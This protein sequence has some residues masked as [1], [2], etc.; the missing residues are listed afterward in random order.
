MIL[1][2]THKTLY[3]Y[4]MPS[5]ESHNEV[6]LMPL[7]DWTQSCIE[8]HLRVNPHCR[9]FSYEETGGTVHYFGVRSAHPIL[10]IIAEAVVETKLENPFDGLNLIEPDWQFYQLH[11][12]LQDNAEFLSE[13]PYVV[14]NQ[15]V[16]DIANGVRDSSND[17]VVDYLLKLAHWIHEALTYDTDATH[18]H[19]KLHEVLEVKAG[20]CQDFAHLMIACCRSMGV[21]ARYVSGYLYVGGTDGMRG[22]QATHAWLECWLPNGKWLA[23]DPTNDLLVNDRYVAVHTGRDYSDVTPTRGVYIGT[24]AKSL[25]VSVSVDRLDVLSSVV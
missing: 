1:R 7:N 21:P 6:R 15:E 17:T 23:I 5:I 20:V 9:V 11:S 3:S 8:F 24:P 18:V 14:C 4:S 16:Q 2:A 25:D 22:E 12:T 13:S 10:E 19:T